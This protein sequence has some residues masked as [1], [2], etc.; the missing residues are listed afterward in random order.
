M[1]ILELTSF[2][3]E[4][5][6]PVAVTGILRKNETT[7]KADHGNHKVIPIKVDYDVMDTRNTLCRSL[8]TFITLSYCCFSVTLVGFI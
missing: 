8:V 5:T 7:C 2:N 3:L 4:T 6:L 1:C